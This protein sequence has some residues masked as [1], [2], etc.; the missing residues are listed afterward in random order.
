MTRRGVAVLAIG[1]SVW[2]VAWLFGGRAL[3]P[4]AAGLVLAVPV[5]LAWV[6][7]SR[8]RLAA[9]RRWEGHGVVEGG[10]VRVDLRV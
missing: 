7:L 3:F 6:R 4:I 9:S 2:F 10:D 5:A 8:Q 1:L